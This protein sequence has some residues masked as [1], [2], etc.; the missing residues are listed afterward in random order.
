MV[1][2]S[3]RALGR[4]DIARSCSARRDECARLE[5]VGGPLEAGPDDAGGW[6]LEARLP[7]IPGGYDSGMAQV[8]A[9]LAV[10]ALTGLVFMA[11]C[12]EGDENGPLAA[13]GTLVETRASEPPS[14]AWDLVALGDS[15]PTGAGDAGPQRSFPELLAKRIAND[16][17]RTVNVTNLAVGGASGDLRVAM[18][19][20]EDYRQA[21]V[22]AEIVTLSI[23][24]NDLFQAQ[25][26]WLSGTCDDGGCFEAALADFDENWQAILATVVEVRKPGEAMLRVTNTYNPLIGHKLARQEMGSRYED[27]SEL[28]TK[29]ANKLNSLI[30]D[31]AIRAG[32]LCADI[33]MIF[34]GGAGRDNPH[35]KGLISEDGVHPSVKGHRTIAA[36]IAQLGYSPLT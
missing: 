16:T 10:L 4:S 19:Q 3:L 5:A 27:L 36:T 17:G 30:C 15:V 12:G 9:R 26:A 6:R 23:G 8:A 24:G 35:A 22:G 33:S 18:E 20:N 28:M 31:N 7:R 34:N 32:M 2:L 11:G 29:N 13:S 25:Q 21:L 1:H 14:A